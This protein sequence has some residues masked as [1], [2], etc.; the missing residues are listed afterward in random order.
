MAFFGFFF[1]MINA[2]LFTAEQVG[3]ATTLISITTLI[4]SLSLL[5]LDNGLI[6]YLPDSVK[7]NEKINSAFALTALTAVSISIIYLK[8]IN[9]FSPKLLFVRENIFYAFLFILFAAFSTLNLISESVFIAY[10]SSKYVLIRNSIFSL[11]KLALPI[12]LLSLGAYG[13]YMSVGIAT[14][15]AVILSIIILLVKFKYT[16][17]P[18]INLEVVNKMAKFSFGNY[19]AG[20]FLVLPQLTLPI[21]I[22]NQ[23]SPATTAYYYIP[24]MIASF[25]FIIPQAISKSFFAEGSYNE[26]G[27]SSFFEKTLK[28]NALIFLPAMLAVYFLGKYVLLF[29]GL[30]YAVEGTEFLQLLAI[31]GTFIY[32]N[33]VGAAILNLKYQVKKIVALNL[34]GAI[35]ILGFSYYL[36]PNG[37]MGIGISWLIGQGVISAIYMLNIKKN[38]N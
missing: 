34:M 3:F 7:K 19:L 6:R 22:T 35:L 2:R 38:I 33:S 13:I 15:T 36:L 8:F 18:K 12:L 4:A 37:L 17:K 14:A 5:G 30:D 29:F 31:S 28:I 1:W 16:F 21:L 26:L 27:I 9:I 23:L 10:L 11:I 25:L 24:M 20:I 32:I